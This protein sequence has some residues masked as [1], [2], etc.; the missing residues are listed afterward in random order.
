MRV[1]GSVVRGEARPESDL[2]LLVDFEPG[3]TLFDLSALIDALR[4]LLGRP[5]DVLTERSLSRYIRAEVLAEA[6]PL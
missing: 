6:R 3:R 2:D 1:F 5:V 4:Q